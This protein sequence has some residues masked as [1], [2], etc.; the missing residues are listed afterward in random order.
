[1]AKNETFDTFEEVCGHETVGPISCMTE[2]ISVC[3]LPRDNFRHQ[4]P[5]KAGSAGSEYHDFVPVKRTEATDDALRDVDGNVR[6]DHTHT[7]CHEPT[8][9]MYGHDHYC[10][11][12]EE[13]CDEYTCFGTL[14]DGTRDIRKV[15]E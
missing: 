1:M 15:R 2:S 9:P 12:E 13:G 8:D 11:P 10:I 14:L 6:P 7:V 3:G 5:D 4:R